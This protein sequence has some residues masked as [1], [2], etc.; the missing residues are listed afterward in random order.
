MRFEIKARKEKKVLDT[1]GNER[2]ER[3][4]IIVAFRLLI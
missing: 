3:K 2:Q 4:E 1:Q